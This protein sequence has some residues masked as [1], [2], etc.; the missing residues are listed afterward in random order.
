MSRW[1]AEEM[2]L[3]MGPHHPSTHGVLRFILHCDGEIVRRLQPDVGYLHRGLEKI[4]EQMPPSSFI[5]FTD[6]IDYLAAMNGNHAWVRAVE[7]LAKIEVPERAQYIRIIA[8][9]MTRIIS[10]LIMLGST[11]MDLGAYTPFLHAIREREVVNDLLE[12]LC[13]QRLTYNY[14]RLGGVAKD[15]PPGWLEKLAAFLEQLTARM[16]EFNTLISN[17]RIFMKRLQGV[18]TIAAERAMAYGL[19]GPNLRACGLA[20][21]LR[22]DHPYS[23]YSSLQFSVPVGRDGYGALGDSYNRFW[24]RVEEVEQSVQ[25]VQ[26]CIKKIS[27]GD[28]QTKVPRLLKLPKGEVYEAVEAPRGELG[29]YLAGDGT[30]K[31]ARVKIRTGSFHAISAMEEVAAGLMVAD[32]VALI[33]TFDLIAPEIDR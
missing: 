33:A 21:D 17:N 27:S 16:R 28:I 14:Y 4:A 18:G 30:E 29:I 22:R 19:T 7:A 2:V 15:L 10:H 5:P 23:L 6:R 8:D 9:E 3:N 24:M 1:T 32:I 12:E 13:G 25:I 11:S 31:P 26:Q 20:Y